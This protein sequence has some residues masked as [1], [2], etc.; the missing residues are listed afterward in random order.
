MKALIKFFTPEPLRSVPVADDEAN[1]VHPDF[2]GKLAASPREGVD[3]LFDLSKDSFVRY[4]DRKCMGTR[5]FLG[6]HSAKVKKFGGIKWRTFEQVE[7]ASYKFGAALRSAGLVATPEVATLEKLKTPCSIAIFENTCAEWMIAAL[8]A[9]SQSISVT[10]I[11]S[12]LGVDA[13]ID[14]VNDGIIRAIVCNKTNIKTLVD[15]IKKM[16]TLK[17]II[18]TDDLVAPGA[19]IEVP[20]APKG[21]NIVAFDDFVESGSTSAFPPHHQR[22]IPAPL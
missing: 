20:T 12:T 22:K 7:T 4:A 16:P 6:Q 10:T 14:A 3:T 13:V 5:E 11:Y 9:F 19:N 15:R 18:Y 21:V 2:K 1:R 17:T 8:G